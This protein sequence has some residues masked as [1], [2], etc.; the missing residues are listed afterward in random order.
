M[1]NIFA[2]FGG[3]WSNDVDVMALRSK[4][5]L[6]GFAL[7]ECLSNHQRLTLV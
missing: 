5:N 7:S 2:K 4:T 6:R 1:K 3:A